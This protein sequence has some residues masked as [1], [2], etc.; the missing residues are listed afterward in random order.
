MFRGIAKSSA[1]FAT[2]GTQHLHLRLTMKARQYLVSMHCN[3]HNQ[4]HHANYY[5]DTLFILP[6]KGWETWY[7]EMLPYLWRLIAHILTI[8]VIFPFSIKKSNFSSW[9][10]INLPHFCVHQCFFSSRVLVQLLR[11]GRRGDPGH[12][13]RRRRPLRW[14][15][16]SHL[17]RFGGQRYVHFTPEN[18]FVSTP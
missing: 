17:E 4:L 6:R 14:P 12:W 9:F 11:G 13:C 1:K 3:G 2:A 8:F 18:H 5:V 16:S 15:S 10:A 7:V